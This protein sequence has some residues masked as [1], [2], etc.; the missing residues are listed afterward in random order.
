MRPT[1]AEQL[2]G[3]RRVLQETVAPAVRS[4]YATEVLRSALDTL[5][6]IEQQWDVLL[7]FLRWDN[8]STAAVLADAA[9]ELP[10]TI[11]R[12]IRAAL[13]QPPGDPSSFED[14][15]ARNLRLRGVLTDVIAFAANRAELAAVTERVR[16][17]L[18]SRVERHP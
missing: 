12:D 18:R 13:D 15:H 4:V 11:A 3:I 10:P 17:H 6:R 7:P 14:L 8:D 5:A 9:P 1:I 2:G 16:G